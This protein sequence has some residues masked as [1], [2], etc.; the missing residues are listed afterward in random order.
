MNEFLTLFFCSLYYVSM[1]ALVDRV[2][3]NIKSKIGALI[4]A[5][6]FVV[7]PAI[8]FLAAVIIK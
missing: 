8:V 1:A 5:L 2:G 7:M 6:I 4:F 3:L